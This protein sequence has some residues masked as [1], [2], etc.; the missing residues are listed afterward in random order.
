[1]ARDSAPSRR[2]VDADTLEYALRKARSQK[3]EE[4]PAP[5]PEGLA[6]T[7]TEAAEL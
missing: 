2:G 6:P 1:M 4:E 5:Q 3:A 7:D